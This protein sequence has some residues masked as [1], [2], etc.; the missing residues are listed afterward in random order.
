MK[1]Q[2]LKRG[3]SCNFVWLIIRGTLASLTVIFASFYFFLVSPLSFLLPQIIHKD[4]LPYHQ[5]LQVFQ[6]VFPF[7]YVPVPFLFSDMKP[8]L[9]NPILTC[10]PTIQSLFMRT[11]FRHVWQCHLSM[12]NV[13]FNEKPLSNAGEGNE[14]GSSPQ[15]ISIIFSL[16]CEN[17]N[18]HEQGKH[19]RCQMYP[20]KSLT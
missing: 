5:R 4:I 12:K 15:V 10:V 6:S 17:L 11:P 2:F 16:S 8:T 13:N 9:I 18:S 3:H 1:C 14:K 19:G 20:F 7:L